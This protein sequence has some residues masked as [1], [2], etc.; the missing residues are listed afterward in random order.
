MGVVS[1]L[2]SADPTRVGGVVPLAGVGYGVGVDK[3]L[4]GD[5]RGK[6]LIADH[7]CPT[8]PALAYV[9][10]WRFLLEIWGTPSTSAGV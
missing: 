5:D 1:L 2:K 8:P 10:L 6:L 7:T 3:R 9:T 4:V